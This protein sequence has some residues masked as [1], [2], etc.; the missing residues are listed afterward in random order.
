MRVH[1]PRPVLRLA[2]PALLAT[3]AFP[4]KVVIEYNHS[5]DFSGYRKY[6]WKDHPFLKNHPE[7]SEYTVGAQLVQSNVNQILMNR[8]Y[9]PVDLEPEFHITHFITARMRQE[10]HTTPVTGPYPAM[11]TWPGA[12]YTWSRAYFPAWDT[13]VENYA[14]GILLLDVV[15][16]KTNQLLWRAACKAKI[17]DMRQR[18]KDVE[19]TVKKALKSFPPRFTPR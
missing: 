17:D 12:W 2:L 7:S 15:D 10:T 13:Y 4:Q 1:I 11:Y 3:A 19:D 18:H 16:A 9:Q 14:E 5:V 8:G 6:D